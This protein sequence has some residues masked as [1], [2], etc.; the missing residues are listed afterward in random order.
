MH[1]RT[2]TNNNTELKCFNIKFRKVSVYDNNEEKKEKSA[3]YAGFKIAG[4]GAAV[5]GAV[6]AFIPPVGAAIA[7]GCGFKGLYNFGSTLWSNAS[8]D[9]TKKYILFEYGTQLSTFSYG[10][11]YGFTYSNYLRIDF[12]RDGYSVYIGKTDDYV[13]EFGKLEG[14]DASKE[15]NCIGSDNGVSALISGIKKHYGGW[16]ESKCNYIN[17]GL[18]CYYVMKEKQHF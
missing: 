14:K 3:F 13:T 2:D 17:T 1:T 11:W 18:F 16:D 4:P 15:F 6:S 5:G 12:E 9:S 7:I 8:V 10:S